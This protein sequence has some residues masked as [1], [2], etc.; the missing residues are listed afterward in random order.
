ML[1]GLRNDM[2]WRLISNMKKN[3]SLTTTKQM[4]AL[5]Q[6]GMLVSET[7]SGEESNSDTLED[8]LRRATLS[9]IPQAFKKDAN[10]S[11]MLQVF[12]IQHKMGKDESF[13]INEKIIKDAPEIISRMAGYISPCTRKDVAVVLETIAS[14][15]SIQV[16]NEVGLEQYFRI[17]LKYPTFLLKDCMEDIIKSY[18]YPRLPLPK[19]FVDRL[20]PPYTY[21][22]R[23]L[24]NVTKTFYRLEI[25]KQ[26]AY[27]DRTKEE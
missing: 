12:E 24:Q 6:T 20:E 7:G 17:L 13:Q 9:T 3:N 11:L 4:E 18:K 25:Y 14:T 16:P 15:F 22:L 27:I 8:R 26:K 10:E 23:W 21:H 2:E 1:N 19:E 5:K